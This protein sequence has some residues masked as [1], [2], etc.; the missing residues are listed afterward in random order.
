MYP[1]WVSARAAT[2]RRRFESA[3]TYTCYGFR[4][5]RSDFLF[6]TFCGLIAKIFHKTLEIKIHNT[7][8][9]AAMQTLKV[10][11][12]IRTR[13]RGGKRAPVSARLNH[14]ASWKSA[15][16]SSPSG[17]RFFSNRWNRWWQYW[18]FHA[19]RIRCSG[20]A[21]RSWSRPS[22]HRARIRGLGRY[23]PW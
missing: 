4:G 21:Q 5:R 10:S 2:R 23:R 6:P 7:S 8:G 11:R 3:A 16:A 19:V 1:G 9:G 12:S 14:R 18:N 20:S 22:G 13:R 17:H 15:T